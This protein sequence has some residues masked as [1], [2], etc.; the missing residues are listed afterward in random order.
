MILMFLFIFILMFILFILMFLNFIL[1]KKSF[2]DR[3]K[4]SS[5]ECGFDVA[6]TNRL[7]FSLQFYLISVIF[8][9]FDVEISLVLPY[10]F[11]NYLNY[12]MLLNMMIYIL[13]FLI[14]GVYMEWLEGALKWF[15]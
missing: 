11:I 1:S 3:E 10:I 9:I 5:F 15:K 8:L 7:P 12:F 13:L 14:L 6:S 2:K 4:M